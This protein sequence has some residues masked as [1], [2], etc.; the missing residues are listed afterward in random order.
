[1]VRV[2]VAH[3]LQEEGK[4]CC[5]HARGKD[6]AMP[7]YEPDGLAARGAVALRRE[8]A[9]AIENTNRTS[10]VRAVHFQRLT[11]ELSGRCRDEM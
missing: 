1:M 3:A 11:L 6:E 5:Q 8:E 9:C 2:R 4:R 7:H 10:T